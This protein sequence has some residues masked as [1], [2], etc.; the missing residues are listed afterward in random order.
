VHNGNAIADVVTVHSYA[1][2]YEIK[3]DTDSIQ[4]ISKQSRYYDL[5]FKKTTLV[6]TERQIV[7]AL[8]FAPPYWGI[9]CGR[10]REDSVSLAY[11][12]P[13]KASPFFD[14]TLALLTL[15]RS[16]LLEVA[17][18]LPSLDEQTRV[19]NLSRADLSE[20][21]A[22]NLDKEKLITSISDKLLS[23]SL[24]GLTT[25]DAIIIA[26]ESAGNCHGLSPD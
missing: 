18:S 16:E 19:D 14:K 1:H 21:I 17:L 8:R 6:T 23:S 9:M 12:R 25:R 24:S 22:K 4:R 7:R 5:V 10:G 13:A 20:L 2:C 15:W 11:V 3:G 26:I